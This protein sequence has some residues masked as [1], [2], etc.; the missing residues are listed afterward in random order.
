MVTKAERRRDSSRRG[1]LARLGDAL[2]A[3]RRARQAAEDAED[4]ELVREARAE[5]GEPIPWD[6]IKRDL[7]L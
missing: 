5:G 3:R 7:G 2:F 1:I 6:Q 4:L